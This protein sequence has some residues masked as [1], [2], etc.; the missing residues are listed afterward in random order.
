MKGIDAVAA[1][2]LAC[3]DTFYTVPGY[4]ISGLAESVG[5]E[6]AVNE[7]VALEYA[8]GDS[9]SGRRAAVI[10]KHVG[11]NACADPLINATTQGL[12]AGVIVVAGDDVTA[13]ASQNAQDSRYYGEIASAPVVEPN[14]ATCMQAVEASFEASEAFSRIAILR[15]TPPLLEGEVPERRCARKDGTGHLA[16]PGLTMRGRATAAEHLTAEMFAWSRRSPLNSISGGTVGVGAAPGTSRAVTVYPPPADADELSSTSEYGRPFLRE[17]RCAEP[18]RADE[19]PERS[20]E[21][22]YYRTFCRGCPYTGVL[23]ILRERRLSVI[24]DM[25]CSV[26]ALN[27]PYGVGVAAY[28]LGSSIAVAARST[29]IALSG[30][31]AV[32]H[33]GINALVDVYEKQLPLLCIVVKNNRMGMTGGHPVFDVVKYLHWAEPIVCGADDVDRLRELL[34]PPE[35]P[36]TVVIEGTCPKGGKHETVAC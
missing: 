21:R 12:R 26:L 19:M 18:P 6:L 9:L 7:K 27:P 35:K 25:G 2:L 32:L 34:V 1:A 3:A 20:K 5:A 13:A 16:A 24:C 28:G 14:A 17:H 31:Y 8:L 10:I 4:P 22:G 30:D 11:L 33:S 23:D 36:V 29:G 15:L